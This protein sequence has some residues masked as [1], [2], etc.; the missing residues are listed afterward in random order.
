MKRRLPLVIG[1]GLLVVVGALGALI[2]RRD[3]APPV[4]AE[5]SAQSAAVATNETSPA[6][7]KPPNPPPRFVSDPSN[8]SG[9]RPDPERMKQL[10][11]TVGEETRRKAAAP[12]AREKRLQRLPHREQIQTAVEEA[13]AEA[14]GLSE[15]QKTR[16]RELRESFYRERRRLYLDDGQADRSGWSGEDQRVTNLQIQ[17]TVALRD[18][19]GGQEKLAEF[20]TTAV[21][22][23][24]R[25]V[26]E[27]RP[28]SDQA[29][30]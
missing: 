26:A 22:E 20:K 24:R 2:A 15:S 27:M 12:E 10:I 4:N 21:R 9:R 11:R 23:Q 5:R 29:V 8:P 13:T 19:L 16:M 30:Q 1:L 28:A 7:V 3:G 6:A 25:I 17:T 14:M 18:L